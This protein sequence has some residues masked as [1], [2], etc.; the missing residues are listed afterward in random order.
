[1]ANLALLIAIACALCVSAQPIARA[2]TP[3]SVDASR[4][5]PSAS[6]LPVPEVSL[7]SQTD[8]SSHDPIISDAGNIRPALDSVEHRNPT[9]GLFV[10]S[11]S[12]RPHTPQPTPT[13]DFRSLK[14]SYLEKRINNIDTIVVRS[15]AKYLKIELEI[16]YDFLSS[17]GAQ[18]VTQKD[19]SI[20]R[21]VIAKA[22][23]VKD[24]CDSG[25]SSYLKE[26]EKTAVML[27]DLYNHGSSL[28]PKA[29]TPA[30]IESKAKTFEKDLESNSAKWI[31][32]E[33]TLEDLTVE[34]WDNTAQLWIL[35]IQGMRRGD[36]E[37]IKHRK[38]LDQLVK[39]A[40]DLSQDMTLRKASV[41]A[42]N[43]LQLLAKTDKEL[44]SEDASGR[45]KKRKAK[46]DN[47]N[48]PHKLYL[49]ASQTP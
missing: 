31:D 2:G 15:G 14:M 34:M 3:L 30:Q 8:I 28:E 26:T 1:M 33:L 45:G 11:P 37:Y 5:F 21:E 25:S 42:N 41:S 40:E 32:E 29:L 22:N 12:P 9:F 47:N 24:D 48:R 6:T 16:T 17:L 19:N 43:F 20:V 27:L 4:T 10:R 39:T 23:I 38:D 13:F 49:V 35:E 46:S 7:S 18:Y 44:L 36:P